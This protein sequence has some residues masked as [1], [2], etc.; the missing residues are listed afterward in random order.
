MKAKNKKAIGNWLLD[1]ESEA[2]CLPNFQRQ[3]VWIPKNVCKLFETLILRNG[4]PIGVFLTLPTN[5]SKPLFPP[6]SIIDGSKPPHGVCN[7]LLLDGQQRLS[8]L[9]K[10]LHDTDRE[11]YRYYVEFN[12]QFEIKKIKE[13]KKDT[14][15]DQR[16]NQNP[17]A[18]YK[19]QWFPVKLLNPL[20]ETEA[21]NDWTQQLDLQELKLDN[22]DLIK[23]LIVNTR[24]IFSRKRLG[25]KIIPHF[26]LDGSTSKD[27]AI[28]I[29]E[30]INTN[31]VKLS[32]YYLAIARMEKKTE[33]SLYDMIKRLDKRI[34]SIKDLESDEIGELIL[35]ISC[36]LQNK[37][38]SG[39]NCEN[40]DFD[41]VLKDESKIFSGI[42]WAIEKLSDLKIYDKG[43]LPSVVPLRVLPALH[44]HVLKSRLQKVKI[45]EIITKYLWHAFLTKRYEDK[46]DSRLKE[47][48]D[49]L[50]KFLDGTLQWTRAGKGKTKIFN[51]EENLH[52]SLNDIKKAGWPRS[53]RIL[54]R[55]ILLVCCQKGAKTLADGE[56][57]SRHKYI[58]R[59]KHHIFPKSRLSD[60]SD[61]I[62]H[63]GNYVLNC[64]LVPKKENK[65]YGND[66]PGDYIEKLFKS[67]GTP[68][69]QVDVVDRFETHL[70]SKQMAEMLVEVTQ[71]AIDN[72]RVILKDAYNEFVDARAHD[73]EREIKELLG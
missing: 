5:Q 13:M 1:I 50:K 71:D 66:F 25:G 51:K 49:H 56:D 23:N 12:D 67:L 31:S 69:P 70:I 32:Y 60:K 42:E 37:I 43:Q 7:T 38:P 53:V 72:R 30:D 46:A 41:I 57:I 8:T 11:E 19:K 62:G 59:E 35:K 14:A 44:Q 73:V 47:D 15:V 24:K 54:A 21:V 39:K 17:T 2:L 3:E 20:V 4:T 28:E 61:G 27:T 65:E 29:Y 22:Y 18:Q 45:N 6:R 68:L 16:L 64:M 33:K 9:W 26:Q 34:P 36:V 52:P 58:K 55:G 10:A 63:S 40:L 48:H